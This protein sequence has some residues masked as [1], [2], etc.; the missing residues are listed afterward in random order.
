MKPA[1]G[2]RLLLTGVLM[3]AFGGALFV[4]ERWQQLSLGGNYSLAVAVAGV[5]VA[6]AGAILGRR[7]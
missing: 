6:V 1:L 5:L 7:R 4:A 3:V 2:D